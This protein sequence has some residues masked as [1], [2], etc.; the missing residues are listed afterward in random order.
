MA[1]YFILLFTLA[2][3]QLQMHNKRQ[4]EQF[5]ERRLALLSRYLPTQ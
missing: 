3:V 4:A 2:Y 1:E 5:K